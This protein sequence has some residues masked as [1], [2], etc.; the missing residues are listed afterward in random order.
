MNGFDFERQPSA[1]ARDVG[2]ELTSVGACAEGRKSH[3]ALFESSVGSAFVDVGR[4]KEGLDDIHLTS[5]DSVE[6]VD[7]EHTILA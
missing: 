3:F 2:E 7:I 5:A 6:F 4:G 1:V